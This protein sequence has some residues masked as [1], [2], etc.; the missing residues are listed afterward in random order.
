MRLAV[1]TAVFWGGSFAGWMGV[2]CLLVVLGTRPATAE[3]L[4]LVTEA[5]PPLIEQNDDGQPTGM[6]WTIAE[7]ALVDLGYQ[8]ELE[9]VPWK[10]A[11]R[12]VAEGQKDGIVGIGYT[13][14]RASRYQ[15][16]EHYLILSETTIFSLAEAG[17]PYTGLESLAGLAVGVSAGYVYSPRVEKANHFHKVRVPSIE[18]GL[19]MLTL[20][21]IDALLGN[22]LVVWSEAEKL[23]L[24]DRLLAAET[25]I[26]GGPVYL[27]FSR[28]VA[29]DLVRA[30]SEALANYR[31][32]TLILTG[33]P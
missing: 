26:S 22:R 24:A 28:S 21:R 1:K 15:F 7:K 9:F 18:S 3:T 20:G 11:Q 32:D 2:L 5:W 17:Q 31:R 29:P 25:A 30:F 8:V 6:M 4:Q 27:A 12:M 14:E 23:G 19:T 33:K 10:R 13:A 16:P